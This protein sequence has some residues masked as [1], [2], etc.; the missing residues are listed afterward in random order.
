MAAYD[1]FSLKPLES[2]ASES[3]RDLLGPAAMPHLV[4]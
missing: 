4:A 2:S 3:P 1:G